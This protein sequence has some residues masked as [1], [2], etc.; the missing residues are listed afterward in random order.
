MAQSD[1][2]LG[3]GQRFVMKRT[4]NKQP[5]K[6]L[7]VLS[8]NRVG[9]S[10]CK[11][12]TISQVWY[13]ASDETL[14]HNDPQ[15]S[16]KC[17]Q[18]TR[19]GSGPW[20]ISLQPCTPSSTKFVYDDNTSQLRMKG[21]TQCVNLAGRNYGDG[22]TVDGFPCNQAAP[23]TVRWVREPVQQKVEEQDFNADVCRSIPNGLEKLF[24][25]IKG[26]AS[27]VEQDR[28]TNFGNTILTVQNDIDYLRA[29]INDSL[30][31]GDVLF[32]T[33]PH[34]QIMQQVMDRNKELK[35]K[36]E[37]ISNDILKKEA[38]IERTDRDFIEEKETIPDSQPKK[39]VRFIEDYSLAILLT[40]Y[41]FLLLS[42]IFWYTI[43]STTILNGLLQ[44]V[45]IG[46]FVSG[47]FFMMLLHIS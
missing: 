7:T 27:N 17:V 37:S 4:D 14:R 1:I 18:V 46:A 41:V 12:D 13:L 21:T 34:T 9:S 45:A 40:S 3:N 25:Q 6:C 30:M 38:M 11:D 42:G 28:I 36:K 20:S 10:D 26:C 29:N 23:D 31:K 24:E 44:G 8:N 39:I 47:L 19:S 43:H 5:N 15:Y 16:N 2:I 32:G 35:D 22:A 33:S